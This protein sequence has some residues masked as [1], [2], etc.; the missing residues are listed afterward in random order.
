MNSRRVTVL[1]LGSAMVLLAVRA[2]SARP[3]PDEKS[4]FAS[5]DAQILSEVR[6]HSQAMDNLEYLS[7]NI[8]QRMTGSPQLKQANEW[9]RDKFT[10]YGLANARL[11]PWAIARSWTRGTARARIL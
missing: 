10:Q 6:E 8:G 7:D 2:G 4:A 11:E 3:S 1:A 5:A 9:T